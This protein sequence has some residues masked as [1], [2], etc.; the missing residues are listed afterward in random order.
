MI[1]HALIVSSLLPL[2]APAP[3][4]VAKTITAAKVADLQFGTF[5]AGPAGGNVILDPLGPL[6]ATG[7]LQPTATP[8][9]PAVFTLTG[10]PLKTFTWDVSPDHVQLDHGN[11]LDAFQ[12]QA[13][14]RSGSLTFDAKGQAQLQIGAT[15]AAAALC[16]PGSYRRDQLLLHVS[17]KG[18]NAS[19]QVS[20]AVLAGVMTPLSIQETRSLNFGTITAQPTAFTVRLT[21]TGQRSLPGGG[22][23][24]PGAFAVAGQP[25]AMV[26]L[27]LPRSGILLKGRGADLVLV[28]LTTDLPSTFPLGPGGRTSFQV[29]GTLK[30]NANQAKGLYT[31]FY[32]VTVNYLF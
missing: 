28:D 12:F 9:G 7:D 19:C 14:C 31:G 11:R 2:A 16:P 6:H 32:P 26:A 10:P 4:Q 22:A 13:A 24:S 3:P 27:S 25:G 17:A 23:F 30:I 1:H 8:S 5:V 29:G 20:F 21:P 15:L 18:S